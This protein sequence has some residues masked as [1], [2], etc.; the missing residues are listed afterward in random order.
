MPGPSGGS[1]LAARY[2]DLLGG[3]ANARLTCVS[4]FARHV[5]HLFI[6]GSRPGQGQ[7]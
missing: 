2:Q 7:S 6:V 1:A 5:Y 4:P 3:M